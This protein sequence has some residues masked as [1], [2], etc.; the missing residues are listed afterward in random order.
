MSD[1]E[2]LLRLEPVLATESRHLED[3]GDR[4]RNMPLW[5]VPDGV[6]VIK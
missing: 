4:M 6:C 1:A 3:M 5:Q 2:Q